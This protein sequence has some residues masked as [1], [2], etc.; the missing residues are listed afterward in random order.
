MANENKLDLSQ[1]SVS[2][3]LNDDAPSNIPNTEEE[4]TPEPTQETEAQTEETETT[5]VVSEQ[6]SEDEGAE[7]EVYE[8]S[9]DSIRATNDE[10]GVEE[11]DQTSIIGT[12]RERL[13]YDIAGD[14][15]DDYEGLVKFTEAAGSEIAKEQLNSIFEQY[16]DVQQYL[17]YRYNGGNPQK[18]FQ[19]TA[20]PVDYGSVVIDE[21]DVATQQNVVKEFLLRTGYTEEE[22]SESV[23]DYLEAGI[24]KRHA[25]RSLT[26]LQAIQKQEAQQLLQRQQQE[27]QQQQAQIKQQWDNIRSTIDKGQVRG[28]TIPQADKNKFYNWMSA[29][30]DKQGRTQRLVDRESLDMETQ[31]AME[32]LLYKGFDLSKLVQATKGTQ[33]AENLKQRLVKKPSAGKRMKGAQGGGSSNPKLP[34]LKELL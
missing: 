10:E 16:P 6:Q 7:E 9:D 33:Q 34:S 31:V 12:L 18:Y 32:Y 24:L 28:F 15:D 27:A 13:G 17:E 3:L 26:K 8:T 2:N 14:Y 30:I 11:D 22:A 19:A 1:V 23:Q 4:A 25:E 21:D 29:P 20:P 5:E